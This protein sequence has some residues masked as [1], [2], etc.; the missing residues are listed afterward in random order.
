[1]REE[2]RAAAAYGWTIAE[3]SFDWPTLLANKDREIAR[4]N[5]V[6]ER[7]LVNNGV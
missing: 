3:P 4:L 6:Y 7:I 5:G 1:M 2:V